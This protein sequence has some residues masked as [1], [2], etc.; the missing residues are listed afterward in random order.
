MCLKVDI[1]FFST[2]RKTTALEHQI[3]R[4][5]QITS[6]AT[7][8]PRMYTKNSLEKEAS[9]QEEHKYPLS[10]HF[11]GRELNTSVPC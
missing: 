11:F 9:V 8:L 7:T 3:S 2:T 5:F 10:R 1:T 6:R 4:T